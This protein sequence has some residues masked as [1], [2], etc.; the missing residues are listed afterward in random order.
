MFIIVFSTTNNREFQSPNWRT[1][2][3]KVTLEEAKIVFENIVALAET[4]QEHGFP[5]FG[6]ITQVAIFK[7]IG[8]RTFTQRPRYHADYRDK[9]GWPIGGGA[10]GLVN[11]MNSDFTINK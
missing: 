10:G 2:T 6:R 9:S 1:V 8:R 3:E 5:Y 7:V 4:K 11:A